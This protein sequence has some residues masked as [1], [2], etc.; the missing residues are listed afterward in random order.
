[1]QAFFSGL[2]P[3]E[4]DPNFKFATVLTGTIEGIQLMPINGGKT[5]VNMAIVRVKKVARGISQIQDPKGRLLPVSLDALRVSLADAQ[6]DAARNYRRY[7]ERLEQDAKTIAALLDQN[8]EHI[9]GLNEFELF[10][11]EGG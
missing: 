9:A 1:M 8:A 5:S 6:Q 7:R 2:Y 3:S 11:I 10:G 4:A